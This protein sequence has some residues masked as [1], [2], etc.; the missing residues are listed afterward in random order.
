MFPGIRRVQLLRTG[1]LSQNTFL[2]FEGMCKSGGIREYDQLCKQRADAMNMATSVTIAYNAAQYFA[3]R[4]T[5]SSEKAATHSNQGPLKVSLQQ[6]LLT[7]EEDKLDTKKW[8]SNKW[9]SKFCIC[10]HTLNT[11]V[12]QGTL[13]EKETHYQQTQKIVK[14]RCTCQKIFHS[15]RSR[16]SPCFNQ[17]SAGWTVKL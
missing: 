3:H 6:W 9:H 1:N 17:N 11:A 7:W 16:T 10:T 15:L 5:R 12:H 13:T 2:W 8:N 4:S 14:C